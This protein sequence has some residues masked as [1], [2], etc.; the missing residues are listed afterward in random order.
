MVAARY[1]CEM[2]IFVTGYSAPKDKDKGPA[3]V[4]KAR[5]DRTMSGWELGNV[6]KIRTV[7][8]QKVNLDTDIKPTFSAED[9]FALLNAPPVKSK[10]ITRRMADP[11]GAPNRMQN[12]WVWDGRPDWD[13]IFTQVKLQRIHPDIGVC[14]CGAPPIGRDIKAMCHKHSNSKEAVQFSLHK[15]NFLFFYLYP[16]KTRFIW[17]LIMYM[18]LSESRLKYWKE[19]KG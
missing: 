10:E 7:K 15:E 14:F 1:H 2:H 6:P 12:L 8:A 5:S 9:L 16:R 3:T 11:K 18:L 13:Q 19:R 17:E 4:A